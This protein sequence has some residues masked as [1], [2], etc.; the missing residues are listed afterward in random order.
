MI[1]SASPVSPPL[2]PPLAASLFLP[3]SFAHIGLSPC[4][5]HP[6]CFFSSVLLHFTPFFFS[7][8][9][10]TCEIAGRKGW[11][12]G[13]S[14]HLVVE[15][16]THISRPKR[17]RVAGAASLMLFIPLLFRL[18]AA[19]ATE[20]VLFVHS[21]HFSTLHLCVSPPS[22]PRWQRVPV[23]CWQT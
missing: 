19:P 21:E 15:A 8:L 14:G 17:G 5:S 20:K 7:L 1:A 22:S 12:G 6:I 13:Q 3:L 4:N 23:P 2:P 10:C 16:P 9:C 18:P 11:G